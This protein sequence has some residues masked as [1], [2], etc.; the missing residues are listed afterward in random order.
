VKFTLTIETGNDAFVGSDGPPSVVDALE[1]AA[2][3]VS[4]GHTNGAIRDYNG[5]AVGSWTFTP[6]EAPD[7]E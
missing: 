3:K 7:G 1:E 5:N 2:Q 4:D 6:E